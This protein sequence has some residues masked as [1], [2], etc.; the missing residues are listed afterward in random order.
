[1][2]GIQSSAKLN[3]QTLVTGMHL[4]P[5]FG[6][7]FQ[8][9][10]DDGFAIDAKVE[11]LLSSDSA[12][13]TAKS[14]GLGL[15]GISEALERLG[16][17]L[18]LLLGDRFEMLAVG[19]AA[20]LLNIPVAHIAGGDTTEGAFDESIRHSLTKM[21]HLHFVTNELAAG[22]VRQLGEAPESVHC[23]GSPGIDHIVRAPLLSQDEVESRLGFALRD[24]NL[25]ITHHPVTLG[26]ND[27]VEEVQALGEALDR[28]TASGMDLG[29]IIT[30]PNADPGGRAVIE[31]I[32]A[33]A[34]ERENVI[35]RVSL[36][37]S[38]Y[39][40]TLALADVVVG[41]SSSG[42]YEA[43]S[44]R[45]PTVNIG[46]RQKGR[47]AAASVIHCPPTAAAIEE[48]IRAALVLD[49]HDV[50]NPY[51]DGDSSTRI[52]KVLEAL[53]DPRALLRKQFHTL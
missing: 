37:H 8:Q 32:H 49:C 30:L 39:L 1:M 25:L 20:L 19:T 11:M 9:I 52:V 12:V 48:A 5:E 28:L 38:L 21:S 45:V 51:G 40:S 2:D 17:D 27:G 31:A 26:D 4:S 15:I 22:R 47:L 36:G 18:V 7:T 6:L 29:C 3:L 41:N 44:L 43:P 50:V 16:P 33:F 23:V 24:V 46:D 53:E 13:G 42:L 14:V 10:E 34:A 35:A